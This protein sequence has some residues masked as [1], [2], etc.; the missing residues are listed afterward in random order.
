MLLQDHCEAVLH[1]STRDEFQRVLVRFAQDLGF[2]FMAASAVYDQA[3]G[4][5]EFVTVH[6]A[7]VSYLPIMGA[8]GAFDPVM[9]HCKHSALPIV[10]D[11]TAYARAGRGELWEE[12]A[13]YGYQTGI[14]M[15]LHLPHGRHF[16]FG[17]D[18]DR[19]LPTQQKKLARMV[20]DLVSVLMFAQDA[21]FHL[22]PSLEDHLMGQDQ[23]RAAVDSLFV[24]ATKEIIDLGRVQDV[25]VRPCLQ[26]DHHLLGLK[27]AMGIPN[28]RTRFRGRIH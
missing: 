28:F 9:Q 2:G 23:P 24:P 11:Q 12:M 22:L 7:P 25:S 27:C 19:R 17:I 18:G 5:P 10:W 13:P 21:A 1:A 8:I 3:D 15:A 14:C 26:M 6:N 20:A 4:R 16:V